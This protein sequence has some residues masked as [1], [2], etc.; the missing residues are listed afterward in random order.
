MHV[1]TLAKTHKEKATTI[2]VLAT[3]LLTRQS[4]GI[5]QTIPSLTQE[6]EYETGW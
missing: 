5:A 2:N 6:E 4:V 1:F 3:V